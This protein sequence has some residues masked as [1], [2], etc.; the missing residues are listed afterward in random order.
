[1]KSGLLNSVAIFRCMKI[2]SNKLLLGLLY[3]VD[4]V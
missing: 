1:M 4:I 3:E 2:V